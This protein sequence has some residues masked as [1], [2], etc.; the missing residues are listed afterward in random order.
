MTDRVHGGPR[1]AELRALGLDPA[2]VLDFSVSTNPYGP[3]PTVVAAIRAAALDR[4]PDPTS[5]ATRIAMAPLVGVPP[6]QLVLGNGAAELLWAVARAVLRPGD[7]ALIAEPT[8][9][10]LRTAAI[11]L[12]ARIRE[13]RAAADR[14]QIDLAA[15]ARHLGDARLVYLCT[16]STP[17]GA[18]VRADEVAA[19]A[20]TCPDTVIVLDQSFLSLADHAE[21]ATVAMPANVIRVR[22]LT[23][24][25]ALAGVRVGYLIAAPALVARIEAQRPAWS[26]SALAQAAARAALSSRAFVDASRLRLRDDRAELVTALRDLGLIPAPSTAPFVLVSVPDATALRA[27]L[28]RHAMLV[29]DCASFGLPGYIRIAA[30]PP[31]DRARLVTALRQEL[32]C[33]HPRS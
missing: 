21:D 3:C 13:W 33:S 32:G 25:H 16:P 20:A 26:T 31:A 11:A 2:H 17:T 6:E 10:E 24:D 12:G 7:T 1:D 30:R 29:R 4:Y 19:W 15:I 5:H 9:S 22:S 8:F 28:A 27:R 14:F 23:K 18:T